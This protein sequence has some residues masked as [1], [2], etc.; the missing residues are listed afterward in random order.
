MFNM[1]SRR[2]IKQYQISFHS[3]N[4]TFVTYHTQWTTNTKFAETPG[5]KDKDPFF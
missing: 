3:Q 2:L 5:D 1:K 4:K